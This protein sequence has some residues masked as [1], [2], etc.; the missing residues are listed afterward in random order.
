MRSKTLVLGLNRSIAFQKADMKIFLTFLFALILLSGAVFHIISPSFYGP[1][2]P[3][4]VS[5]EFANIVSAIVEGS[6]GIALLIPRYRKIGALGFFLLMLAFLP[7]HIWD[8]MKDVP[9]VGSKTAAVVRLVIQVVL[10]YGGWWLFR[11]VGRVVRT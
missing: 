4:F 11:K 10:I 9:A 5:L 1:I 8:W 6:I 7:I 3:D 2:T